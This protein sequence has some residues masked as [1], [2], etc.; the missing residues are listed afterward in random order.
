MGVVSHPGGARSSLFLTIYA[1]TVFMLANLSTPTPLTVHTQLKF[2]ARAFNLL[3][4]T[5]NPEEE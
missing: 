3:K 2:C 4:S 1:D 5:L